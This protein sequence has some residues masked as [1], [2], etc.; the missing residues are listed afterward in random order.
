MAKRIKK[1]TLHAQE[2]L[3]HALERQ[4]ARMDKQL[5]EGLRAANNRIDDKHDRL[6]KVEKSIYDLLGM[7]VGIGSCDQAI[8]RIDQRLSEHA[9]A[10]SSHLNRIINLEQRELASP[11]KK[12]RAKLYIDGNGTSVGSFDS[13]REAE[14]QAQRAKFPRYIID[15]TDED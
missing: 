14:E 9:S 2:D 8:K 10:L 7:E 12:F 3:V 6:L 1:P 11:R 4:V 13:V 5:Q 15:W